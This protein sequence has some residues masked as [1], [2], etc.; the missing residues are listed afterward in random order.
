MLPARAFLKSTVGH[1]GKNACERCTV[2]GVRLDGRTVFPSADAEE[3]TDQSFR[4]RDQADH[5]H[6][7]TALLRIVPSLNIIV[8]SVLDSMHLLYQGIMKKLLEYWIDHGVNKLHVTKRQKLS[9][10]MELLK[11]QVPCEV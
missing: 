3:R 8:V 1:V 4:A 9:R 2:Q 11:Q 10:R 7:F 6:G 5:H